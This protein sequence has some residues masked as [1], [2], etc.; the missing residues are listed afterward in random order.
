MSPVKEDKGEHGQSNND[1]NNSPVA[2]KKGNDT[3][4]NRAHCEYN[5]KQGPA[6]NPVLFTDCFNTCDLL[7]KFYAN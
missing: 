2:D 1:L 4:K 5:L 7:K 3:Q 6:N